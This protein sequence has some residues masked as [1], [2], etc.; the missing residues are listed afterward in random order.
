MPMGTPA[1]AVSAV[2][3]Q[4]TQKSDPLREVSEEMREYLRELAEEKKFTGTALVVRHGKVLLRTAAGAAD[5]EKH[6]PNRPDTVYRIASVTKQFTSMIVLK[7]RDR[8][9]LGLEDKVCPYLIP[10]YLKSCPRAW[11][12]ITIREIV[13]H[14]SGIPDIQGLPDFYAK[15][16]Q[17]TTTRKLIQ[18]FVHEPLDFKPGTSWKYSNSGY[19]LAGAIIQVV[20]RDSYGT[21]LEDEITDP[22]RL[23]H[24]GYSRRNPPAG[25]AKGYF[26]VGSPAPPINGSQ[27]F[28]ATGI[29]ST[30]DDIARWDRAF[31]AHLVAPPATVKQA[32]TPQAKCPATGCLNLPSSAY[33]FGW[34]VDELEGH[35][36]RYHPG[37][38]QGYAASNMYLVDDDIVVVVLSNVQDTDTN[39]IAR[40][41]ATMVLEA[42]E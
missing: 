37:L 38:L 16:S 26:T 17:P 35:R 25:Y 33:A 22:L 42:S 24:T 39:G 10:A 19:I 2:T 9:L 11:K 3:S 32:F 29:Y 4:P 34:L 23:R 15:L 20:T 1:V 7:L 8:G 28:S 27:A 30:V 31:G 12:P 36:L 40:H 6:I 18:R 14:T 13:T 41:L 21:V 5:E